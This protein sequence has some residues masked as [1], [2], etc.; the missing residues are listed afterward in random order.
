LYYG[1]IITPLNDDGILDYLNPEF[2]YLPLG[3]EGRGQ[4]S[5]TWSLFI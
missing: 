2:W 4:K 1:I 5:K 3:A